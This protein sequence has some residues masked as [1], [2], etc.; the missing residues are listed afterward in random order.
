VFDYLWTVEKESIGL[1]GNR[2]ATERFA[3]VA[4][5]VKREMPDDEA[6]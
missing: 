4:E 6:I 1:K 2:K 3:A 5:I